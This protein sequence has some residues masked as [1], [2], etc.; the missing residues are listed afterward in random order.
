[1]V[2]RHKLIQNRREKEKNGIKPKRE[3]VDSGR[4]IYLH[5]HISLKRKN[6]RG[7]TDDFATNFL[8]FAL[9]SAALWN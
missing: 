6:C 9:F 1:M 2:N 5:L 4:G 3:T 7:T 8:H